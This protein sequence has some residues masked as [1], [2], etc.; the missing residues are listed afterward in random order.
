[1]KRHT[2]QSDSRTMI[3]VILSLAWPTMMEQLLQTAV[4]YIDTAMV[5]SLGTEATAAVGATT[6][7]N[8][9]IN[10][11]ISALGIGFLA[12]IAKAYGAKDKEA[13]R[14]AV[15]QAVLTV[16]VVGS[17]FTILTLSLSGIIPVWMQVEKGIQKLAAQ[18]FFIL[19]LPMLPRTA[20]LIF[21][22]VLRAAGDT[23]TPMK[24]GL[25]MNLTNVVLN[26]LLIY[27]TRPV[28]IWGMHIVL[29]GAGLGVL[30]AAMA[31]AIAFFVG[32]LLMTLAVWRHPMLSFRGASLK[33]DM[34]ILRPCM[35]VA[36]PNLL[37]RFGTSL[38]YVAF[39]SMINS[40]GEVATAAHT[41]A[42]TVESA[43]YIPGYG[44]QTAAAT[45]AGN[46]Y[47]ANDGQ[48]MKAIA[49]MFIPIEIILM[50]VSGG[51]LFV[52]APVLMQLFSKSDEVVLLGSTVLRMVA[53]SEPF[54][55][56]SIIVEGFLMGVGKT[57]LP[58]IYNI[59]GMWGVRII[60]TLIC[61]QMLDM[62]L[63]SAWACM[64]A[65]NL[66]LFVLF[67]ICYIRGTWNPLHKKVL[68]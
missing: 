38:G 67:L 2:N 39:A 17:F 52:T 45:L 68:A 3:A 32:G 62:G 24:A 4:Q 48:R 27:E 51:L 6:T 28:S 61:T 14:Q 46:A 55:G 23:K 15:S 36:I 43:F 56:F 58:F 19:Y 50:I 7:I 42:N 8:W 34:H 20:S 47:G 16:L 10:G 37:Q 12:F 9:L 60:G 31:S 18:Y 35:R 54:Y 26:F 13:A 21:G 41:I 25:L 40:L 65:H 66:L 11:S 30:G 59:F 33:P 22:A 49:K 1:M 63:V 64:I 57:K 5:G 53:I 44:M 29:P